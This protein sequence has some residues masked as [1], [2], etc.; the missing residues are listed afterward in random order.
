MAVSVATLLE[1][2]HVNLAHARCVADHALALFDG[3]QALHQLSSRSRSLLEIGALLHNIAYA[4]DQPKHHTLGRNMILHSE[5]EGLNE[6][7]HAL[8]ACLVAFHRKKVRPY[9]EAA[10]LYLSK[11]QRIEA[12]QL[13]ALLRIADGLDYCESQSTRICEIEIDGN[14]VYLLV[15]GPNAQEDAA[16]ASEKADLWER[17]FEASLTIST[18]ETPEQSGQ[19]SAPPES[20]EEPV[21]Q[22]LLDYRERVWE[23]QLDDHLEVAAR[24]LLLQA[25]QRLLRQERAVRRDRDIEAVHQMRV[26]IRQFR[27][28]LMLLGDQLD[29][30]TVQRFQRRLRKLAK[31]LGAVRDRDVLLLNLSQYSQTQAFKPE[32]LAPV[33][34]RLACERE[35]AKQELF[36][37]LDSEA[38]RE[39]KQE[40]A[41]FLLSRPTLSVPEHQA[42]PLVR[43]A[44]GSLIWGA[45]ERVRAYETLL[46]IGQQLDASHD[47][48]TLHALRITAKRLRYALEFCAPALGPTSERVIKPLVALQDHLGALN[49]IDV[50]LN[51]IGALGLEL[52]DMPALQSYRAARLAEQEY[53]L[54]ELP[55]AWATLAGATYRR[56]LQRLI[57][58]L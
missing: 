8:V 50:A 13:A 24:K 12:L 53:L 26:A 6:Q 42:P 4:I 15:E 39:T 16:R 36:A 21:D 49:D 37:L 41:R 32:A 18:S 11:K 48:P 44:I 10:F 34:D 27:A 43:Y 51:S 28:V 57:T 25:F 9:Y 54:A 2:Y 22:L 46:P 17:A 33:S 55:K 40:L 35:Q 14:D 1:R 7:E 58:V 30:K 19:P 29:P 47:I 3:T 38:Y 5:I 20:E 23:L 45:Y 31:R 56:N 52:D